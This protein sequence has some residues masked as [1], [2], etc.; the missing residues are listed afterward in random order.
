MNW[1]HNILL[2]LFLVFGPRMSS[3]AAE[4][5]SVAISILTCAPGEELYSIYGHNAIRVLD[6]RTGTD[7]VYNYGTFDFDT[8]GFAL[9][10]MRGKLPYMITA[11]D[12]G[13]F[14]REY[15]YFKRS[16]SEQIINFTPEE[17]TRVIAYLDNNMLPQNRTYKYDFFMDNCA[18]RLRDVLEKNCSGVLWDESQ[19]SGKTFRQIIKEY[20]RGLPWTDFGIDLIIGAPA[21]R[22][23]TLREESFIPD[24]LAT[25][26]SKAGIKAATPS[27][28][29]Y[30]RSEVLAFPPRDKKVNFLL[31]P[32]FF[33]LLLLVAELFIFVKYRTQDRKMIRMYDAAWMWILALAAVLMAFMWLGTDHVPTKYNWNLLWANPLLPLWWWKAGRSRWLFIFLASCLVISLL[34][35]LTGHNFLPQFFH[36]VVAVV[37]AILL[38]KGWRK[39]SGARA[40]A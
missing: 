7:R 35:A 34:N 38:L 27:R 24:Y 3:Y 32:M 10:F 31:T 17:K 26:I 22:K 30:Y 18:T 14:L 12:Y 15:H 33:F 23:T 11:T 2:V 4:A 39:F 25:G 9:K 28:L 40:V 29:E 37:C 16:V 13:L 19:A 8:P 36:P 1:R 6:L 20:Q 5:D 21:D